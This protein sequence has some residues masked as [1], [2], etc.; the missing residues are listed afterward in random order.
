MTSRTRRIL[1]VY[2]IVTLLSTVFGAVQSPNGPV[3]MIAGGAAG[4]LI[5]FWLAVFENSVREVWRRPLRRYQAWKIALVRAIV[6]LASFY[7]VPE[8]VGWIVSLL[9]PGADPRATMGD[10]HI[11][12][13]VAFALG[14]NLL[15][16]VRR[17][18]GPRNLI[19]LAVGRYH[20]ARPEER[21]VAFMDLKGSTPLAEKLGPA[22]YHD[23]LNDV[24]FDAA[25]PILEHG[26]EVYQYVGDEIVV[27]WRNDR[28]LRNAECV[29]FLFALEDLLAAHRDVYLAE[30]DAFPSLRG[31]LHIGTLMVGEIG[32]LNRQIV[33]IGDT[34]NTASRI[35]GVCRQFHRDYVASAALMERLQALPDGVIRE[36]LGTV[37]LAGKSGE[38]ELFALKRA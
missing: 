6:Y 24:F 4:A 2:A 21:V 35:E 9:Q 1:S 7:F 32:D 12:L 31:A 36:S 15:M 38:T 37:H 27:T 8:L 17:M 25:G 19:A 10:R 26:G 16:A 22:R 3:A 28:G 34:M 18:L 33:M 20:R 11:L 14:V 5:G 30:Y 23:F 13:Y 29:A